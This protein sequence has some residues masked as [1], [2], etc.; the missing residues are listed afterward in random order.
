MKCIRLIW[1]AYCK[2]L[3]VIQILKEMI[4]MF[5]PSCLRYMI[6]YCYEGKCHN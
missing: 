1:V 4:L 2:H 6:Q 3:Q 5:A